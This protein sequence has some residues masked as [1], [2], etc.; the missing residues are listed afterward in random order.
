MN[1]PPSKQLA[2]YDDNRAERFY[3]KLRARIAAWLKKNTGISDRQREYLLL[4]PDLFA[5]LIRLLRDPRIDT[6]LRWQLAAVSLYAIS[7][8][9]LIPDAFMPAGLVDDTVA[10]AFILSRVV[11]IMG[12]AGET[13]LREHWEGEGDALAQIQKVVATAD[14]VL[15]NVAVL[16]R[17]RR[18]FG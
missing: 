13:I 9:D 14:A 3:S 4:L 2:T 12:E 10:I 16:S 15:K 17:L 5:L 11:R 18:R 8:I 7:P 6:S 1:T